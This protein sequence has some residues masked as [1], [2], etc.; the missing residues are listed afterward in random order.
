M[1]KHMELYHAQYFED[2]ATKIGGYAYKECYYLLGGVIQSQYESAL[3][4]VKSGAF[5]RRYG[6]RY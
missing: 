4:S 3:L 2:G 6:E 5:V 1:I